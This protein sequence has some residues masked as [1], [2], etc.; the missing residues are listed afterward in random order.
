MK[1][2]E[3]LGAIAGGLMMGAG[4]AEDAVDQ[5]VTRAPQTETATP[6]PE[7]RR[8]SAEFHAEAPKPLEQFRDLSSGVLIL[9]ANDGEQA[10]VSETLRARNAKRS[11]AAKFQIA[12]SGSLLKATTHVRTFADRDRSR[13]A[14]H[15][16]R[17]VPVY[18]TTKDDVDGVRDLRGKKF[19]LVQLRGHTG[20]MPG[21]YEEAKDFMA[22]Q[23]LLVLGG[24]EGVQFIPEFST[25]D[26]PVI[27]DSH[28]GESAVN[29]YMIVRLIDE[30]GVSSNWEDLHG[31]IAGQADLGGLGI[32]MPGSAE[33]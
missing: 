26:H 19:R 16:L 24:C 33:Y 17:E 2:R 10:A 9:T 13:P 20:D 3:V 6:R 4:C 32:V 28:I 29:T 27:A 11:A 7:R 18:V 21:L 22:D 5:P 14:Q 12:R 1:R 30:I 15:A 25:P 23:S 31:R 8:G